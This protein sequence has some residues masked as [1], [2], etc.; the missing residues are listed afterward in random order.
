[1]RTIANNFFFFKRY[2][3]V[4]IGRH[5][6]IS[7]SQTYCKHS[8]QKIL[9][10][11][12]CIFAPIFALANIVPVSQDFKLLDEA[13]QTIY[14]HNVSHVDKNGRLLSQFEVK[15]SFFPICIYHVL[16]GQH[17]GKR[18]TLSEITKAGFNCVHLWEG[19]ALD[20]SMSF[21]E[22]QNLQVLFH[23][24]TA[25]DVKKYKEHPSILGW[26]LDEEP[27]SL[28]WGNKMDERYQLFLA[29][30]KSFK[31]IDSIHPIFILD[32]AW[33]TF[34][35][36]SWWA[37]WS[38]A[39][40]IAVHDNYPIGPGTKSLSFVNGI[41]ET[42]SLSVSINKE[43][44]PVWFVAQAFEEP[45]PENYRWSMPSPRELRAMIYAAIA[46]GA[47]GIIYFAYDSWVTR[48]GYILGMAPNPE[49]DYFA[50]GRDHF[51]ITKSQILASKNLWHAASN[52]NTEINSLKSFL[53]SKTSS[54][55]YKVS[56]QGKPFSKTPIRCILKEKSN[57]YALICVN[58]D[59]TPLWVRF[60]FAEALSFVNLPI[61]ETSIKPNRTLWV[62]RYEEYGVRVYELEFANNH[63]GNSA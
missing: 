53:L 18:H 24:P 4:R 27:T 47:T 46:H 10:I 58:I 44:K 35:A 51:K 17:Y 38:S 31:S 6:D 60:E 62:D 29:K 21:L 2:V 41:P 3:S 13:P 8:T 5:S 9:S 37:K 63:V 57:R 28:Y 33:I 12:I 15:R 42:V 61:D 52:L 39:S 7:W 54:V 49:V 22:S 16:V 25:D 45:R 14:Q 50:P 20:T 56:I 55:N 26:Y 34:P 1:M 36:N 32:S 59:R 48:N 11:A 43:K 40:D 23:N 19:Q 30:Q